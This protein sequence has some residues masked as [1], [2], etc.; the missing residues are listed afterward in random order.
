M[1]QEIS[2]AVIADLLPLYAEGLAG[3]ETARAVEAHL[4]ACPDCR[5]KYERMRTAPPAGE[6]EARARIQPLRRLR[7]HVIMN[8]LGF[9]LWLPLLLTAAAVLLTVYACI[10]VAVACLWCV[11]LCLGLCLPAGL[12]AAVLALIQSL[13]GSALTYVGLALA[14][15]GLAVLSFFP[16]L[17]LSRQL[18]RL[19]VWLWR[20]CT[21]LFSRRKG[22][23]RT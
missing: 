2:C 4:A 12:L 8:I 5:A 20:K 23:A 14:G 9:P 13:P 19:T 11:L 3:E 18:V 15:G 10:W 1:S 16:C 21:G 22:G 7:F 17:W 6:A